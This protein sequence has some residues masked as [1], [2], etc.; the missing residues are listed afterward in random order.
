MQRH[1]LANSLLVEYTNTFD[2]WYAGACLMQHCASMA[3]ERKGGKTV[4]PRVLSLS[5]AR[6]RAL[7]LSLS[8]SL[9]L[10]HTHTLSLT[11][12]LSVCFSLL[13]ARSDDASPQILLQQGMAGR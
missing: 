6:A 12:T 5:L 2:L 9:S 7:S 1:A 13:R 11:L 10:T 8:L 4:E 3:S